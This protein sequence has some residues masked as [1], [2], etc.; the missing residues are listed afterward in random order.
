FQRPEGI[1]RR[2]D[3]S[4]GRKGIHDH[5]RSHHTLTNNHHQTFHQQSRAATYGS[6]AQAVRKGGVKRQDG[7]QKQVAL[8]YEAEENDMLRLKKAFIGVVEH[9]GMTY[10]IQNTFHSQGYFGV[11]VTPLGLNLTLLEG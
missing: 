2:E 11:K 3:R 1:N 10:N 9:P 6:Y 4:I 7:S 8:T 5:N